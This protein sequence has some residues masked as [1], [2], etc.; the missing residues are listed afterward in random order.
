M[1]I[2][3]NSENVVSALWKYVWS[4][5]IVADSRRMVVF[6]EKTSLYFMPFQLAI[7]AKWVS[8]F[9]L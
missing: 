3:Y 9:S 1:L 4:D 5:R 7:Y 2:K 6:L 8:S